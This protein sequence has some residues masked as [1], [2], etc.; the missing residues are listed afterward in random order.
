[1]GFLSKAFK[2]V[3]PTGTVGDRALGFGKPRTQ[4]IDPILPRGKVGRGP[5]MKAGGKTK[6]MG[7]GGMFG[8]GPTKPK[9]P[10]T[11]GSWGDKINKI[12]NRNPDP[13]LPRGK[14]GKGDI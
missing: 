8:S 11:P 4:L 2:K 12:R 6:E 3:K 7:T 9:N 5:G 13:I 10:S 14:K 1:M